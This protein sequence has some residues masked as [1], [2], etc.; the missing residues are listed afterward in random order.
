M[1][2]YGVLIHFH[3]FFSNIPHIDKYVVFY[4]I[5]LFGVFSSSNDQP[6]RIDFILLLFNRDHRINS[7]RVDIG[8]TKN[9]R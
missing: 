3:D 4:T 7:C 1:K 9:G 5:F 8:M 6:Q 2:I